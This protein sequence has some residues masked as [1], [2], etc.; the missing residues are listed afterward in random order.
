MITITRLDGPAAVRDLPP[1]QASNLPPFPFAAWISKRGPKACLFASCKIPPRRSFISR[2]LWRRRNSLSPA[3]ACRLRGPRGRAGPARIRRQ[4]FQDRAGEL[5][6][7]RR[8]AVKPIH[9]GTRDDSGVRAAADFVPADEGLFRGFDNAAQCTDRESSRYALGCVQLK[10]SSGQIFAIPFLG[11]LALTLL[12]FWV[13]GLKPG[14]S[15]KYDTW[16]SRYSNGL[17]II[18]PFLIVLGIMS[19]RGI[20]A[21]RQPSAFGRGALDPLWTPDGVFSVELPGT[22]MVTTKST[23]GVKTHQVRYWL[24][25]GAITR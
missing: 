4:E 16:H 2:A 17:K 7:W 10:G 1:G 25:G 21:N 6:G 19:I 3:A 15:P 8:A 24:P 18:G 22:P 23:G 9:P 20:A 13:V 11:G 5:V 12:A 14:S